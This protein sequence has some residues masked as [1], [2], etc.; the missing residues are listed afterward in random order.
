[1]IVGLALAPKFVTDQRSVG[2]ANWQERWIELA[3]RYVL[4]C[5]PELFA[6][7]DTTLAE[8]EGTKISFDADAMVGMAGFVGD[9][10]G[11]LSLRLDSSV[12]AACLPVHR[13]GAPSRRMLFD[14]TSELANQLV[15]RVKLRLSGHGVNFRVSAPISLDCARMRFIGAT[16]ETCRA[17]FCTD[18][19]DIEVW[20]DG[21]VRQSVTWS[22]AFFRDDT[23]D[24]NVEGSVI[25]L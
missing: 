18:H 3:E 17:S 9:V 7:Y 23:S 12:V 1:M 11:V 14:W 15:G 8:A 13:E 4:R 19:G 6:A 2:G 24:A 10:Y 16:G 21:S 25:F 22:E 20:V 5:T